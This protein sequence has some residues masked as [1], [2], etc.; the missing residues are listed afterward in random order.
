MNPKVE[1]TMNE[2]LRHSESK[3]LQFDIISNF[4]N[5]L[6]YGNA[7]KLTELKIKSVRKPA[8]FSTYINYRKTA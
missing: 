3:F 6:K 8:L 2:N 1:N 4:V 7:G 5:S